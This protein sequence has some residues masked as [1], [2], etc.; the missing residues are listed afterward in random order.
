[1]RNGQR[2]WNPP[3]SRGDGRTAAPPN[4]LSFR[5]RSAAASS[6]SPEME[7]VSGG[8]RA[9]DVE[10]ARFEERWKTVAPPNIP[11][12]RFVDISISPPYCKKWDGSAT[13]PIKECNRNVSSTYASKDHFSL[14]RSYSGVNSG[15]RKRSGSTDEPN[16]SNSEQNKKKYSRYSTAWCAFRYD[17]GDGGGGGG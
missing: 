4:V 16:N 5:F 10:P 8:E 11:W 15:Q 6:G 7:H 3:A 9:K 12:S 2:T 13:D 17:C 1:M 14:F